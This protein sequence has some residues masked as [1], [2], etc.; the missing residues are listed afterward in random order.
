MYDAVHIRCATEG[1]NS[2]QGLVYTY[3][4]RVHQI[5]IVWMTTDRL[6]ERMGS[7]PNLLIE[8]SVSI[9]TVQC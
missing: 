4:R 2:T 8:Q 5:Y 6:T 3:R 7:V 9:G 1:V